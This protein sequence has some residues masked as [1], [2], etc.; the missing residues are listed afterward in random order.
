MIEEK[1]VKLKLTVID[2]PGFAEQLDNN[3]SWE[4]IVDY[5]KEQY[6]KYQKEENSIT[7]KKIIQDSRVHVCLY[8]IAPNGHR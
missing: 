5:I 1:G 8:F 6:H 4:P 7:R 3:K 2:T